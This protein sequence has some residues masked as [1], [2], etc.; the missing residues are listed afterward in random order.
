MLPAAVLL[1]IGMFV[2]VARQKDER[3]LRVR[4]ALIVLLAGLGMLTA[5]YHYGTPILPGTPFTPTGQ[6]MAVIKV[7]GGGTTQTLNLPVTITPAQ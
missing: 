2:L 1:L 6:S 3:K 5:C 7:S 4:F